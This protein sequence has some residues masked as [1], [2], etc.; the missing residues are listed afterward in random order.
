M[1]AGLLGLV[2]LVGGCASVPTVNGAGSRADATPA[3]GGQSI[4]RCSDR[5]PDRVAWYCIIGQVLYGVAD[6]LQPDP[7]D[8]RSR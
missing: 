5:D 4:T 2:L 7:R 1:R 6:A 8:L 3:P